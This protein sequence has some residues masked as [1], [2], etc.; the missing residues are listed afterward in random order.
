[1]S[2]DVQGRL[3]GL[4]SNAG[5]AGG[6]S[7]TVHELANGRV[8]HIHYRPMAD[9]AWVATHDDITE[10]RKLCQRLEERAVLLQAIIDNFPGAVGYFDRDLRV[11]V[12]NDKAKTILDLPEALFA[13]GPPRLEDLIRFNAARGEYGPGNR[14]EQIAAK[15]A[16]A[17]DRHTYHFER[18]R[19]DGTVL[20]V[21]GAP[22][23]NGGFL[24]TYMDIT[25]RY[26]PEAKIA[27]MAT[28]DALTGLARQGVVPQ[29]ARGG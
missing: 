18:Q 12:C 16:L 7:D 8:F 3:L 13:G 11:A 27:H 25:E 6:V 29:A 5:N 26:R 19:P 1:V 2:E 28:H 22:I 23:D 17:K 20:D 24:T 10:R 4:G 9:G 15:V 14:D 21:R